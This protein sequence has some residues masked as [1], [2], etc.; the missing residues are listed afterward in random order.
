MTIDPNTDWQDSWECPKNDLGYLLTDLS[1]ILCDE[2][3]NRLLVHTW[4]M[5]CKDNQKWN[6]IL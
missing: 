1:E 2:Q 6:N 4:D 5:E 3:W